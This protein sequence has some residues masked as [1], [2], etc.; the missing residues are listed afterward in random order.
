MA[1]MVGRFIRGGKLS[2][3]GGNEAGARGKKIASSGN[4]AKDPTTSLCS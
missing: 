3:S 1:A 2:I 4:L